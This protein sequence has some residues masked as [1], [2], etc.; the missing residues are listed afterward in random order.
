[1]TTGITF[2]WN[3]DHHVD[4]D[5]VPDKVGGL[6]SAYHPEQLAVESKSARADKLGKAGDPEPARPSGPVME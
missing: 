2:P 5:N 1:M 3:G 6:L 4:F